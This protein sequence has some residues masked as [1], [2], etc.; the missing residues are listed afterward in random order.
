MAN[1][2]GL[3]VGE[4]AVF[5][6][7]QRDVL[8]ETKWALIVFGMRLMKMAYAPTATIKNRTNDNVKV[9]EKT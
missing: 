8:Y 5:A 9:N 3:K 4:V 7:Q 2:P 1:P 6:Q